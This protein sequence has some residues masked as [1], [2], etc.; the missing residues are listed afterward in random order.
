[1]HS[2]DPLNFKLKQCLSTNKIDPSDQKND[3]QCVPKDLFT[4]TS[5]EKYLPLSNIVLKNYDSP[6][7]V[8]ASKPENLCIYIAKD[9]T[10]ILQSL[11]DQILEFFEIFFNDTKC[12]LDE[13]NKMLQKRDGNLSY[14]A[15]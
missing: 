5:N 4:T 13:I 3:Y 15:L 10:A 11:K 8:H 9:L 7:L 14:W 1:M 2:V 12:D 6:E